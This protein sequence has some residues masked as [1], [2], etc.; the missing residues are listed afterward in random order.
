MTSLAEYSSGQ[1]LRILV[2]SAYEET[3]EQVGKALQGWPTSHRI[4]WVAQAQLAQARAHDIIPHV[5][6][7]DDS[8]G[9]AMVV[10]TIRALSV[11]VPSAVVLALVDAEAVARDLDAPVEDTVSA[12]RARGQAISQA[13][14]AVLAGARGFVTKPLQADELIAT[15]Q[16]ALAARRPAAPDSSQTEEERGHIIVLCA[17]KGGTGRTTMAINTALALRLLGHLGKVLFKRVNILLIF[18]T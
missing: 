6:L 7:V 8:L 3:R 15:L 10:S 11:Q 4:Y 14:Q 5:I 13:R 18:L 12:A 9:T 17:P 2:V 16:Q 1:I